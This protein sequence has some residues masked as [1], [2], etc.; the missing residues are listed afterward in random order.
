MRKETLLN[1]TQRLAKVGGWYAEVG[2][3]SQPYWTP[4]TYEIFEYQACTPP[5][6]EQLVE[7]IL[8]QYRDIM[9]ASYH[10]SVEGESSDIE[11]E[12][13]TFKGR[14][15]WIRLISD[16]EM[17]A[18]GKVI[19]V[20]GAVMDITEQKLQEHTHRVL[21]ERLFTTFESMTDA[22]YMMD[23]DWRLI[24]INEA[25]DKL[26]GRDR[27]FGIGRNI[28]EVFPLLM[29][30]PLYEGF[31]A[32]ML[33]NEPF[34]VEYYS[35]LMKNW[36]ELD[37]YPS[38]E[39]LS[40]FFHSI[41]EKRVMAD[42]IA[43]SEQRLKYVTQATLDAAWDWNLEKDAVWWSGRL[44]KLFCWSAAETRQEMTTDS[45]YWLERIHPDERMR[46]INNLENLIKSDNSSWV[47]SYRLLRENGEYAN[48]EHR[49]FIA[50]GEDGQ[51]THVVGGITD[52]SKRVEMEER[53]LQSQRLE[54]IGKLTGHV[55][56][57][58][59]N[60][61]TVILGNA[62]LLQGYLQSSP[63]LEEMAGTIC[64]AAL[65]GSDLT[66]RLLAFARRQTLEPRSLDLNLLVGN[67]RPLLQRTL[68]VDIDIQVYQN[69]NLLPAL[70]DANQLEGAL[71]NLCLNARDAMPEGGKLLIETATAE[72]DGGFSDVHRDLRPGS[73]V[74]LSVTDSGSGIPPELIKHVIEP[75]FT[76]KPVG[77]GTGLGLSSVFGFV[78]QSNGNLSI[79]S[80]LG[81]GTTVRLYLPVSSV[82][83]ER[84]PLR[85][86]SIKGGT[87]TILIVDDDELVRAVAKSLLSH[88]LGYKVH[89]MP[90]ARSALEFLRKGAQ[91]D[92]VFTDVMMPGMN[93]W[94]FAR[95]V[96]ASWP[97][98]KI[99][100][101]SGF[102]E[103]SIMHDGNL[104]DDFYLL[105]KPYPLNELAR[106]IRE[107]LD[108][109]SLLKIERN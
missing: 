38:P 21:S 65:K 86:Q 98:M 3:S 45:Y 16:P 52:I 26:T 30:T 83:A 36:I 9:L 77:K 75:F 40:V 78:K 31:H 102:T 5:H 14:H 42:R 96:K 11:V 62:E 51:A 91:V 104:D 99:L 97:G 84:L 27:S 29:E 53:M 63:R 88:S 61:L 22:F 93:G 1:L 109:N 73:Y 50:R 35:D 49:A 55:A 24:Y 70:A 105:P 8:P 68:G 15:K 41:T 10:R 71:L 46:V 79:Y 44:E 108:E 74:V 101:T 107:V 60:L 20:S 34:H 6:F 57:D 33:S 23:Q 64:K 54:S 7:C 100:F 67:M 92:L 82:Q 90:D 69:A 37:A 59:N 56:H 12:M 81:S 4:E 39:G 76:T 85:L 72:I 43:A 87:E 17:D 2:E 94:E 48:V 47:E 13:H 18:T 25:A 106:K 58:F 80:E 19:S 32:A 95:Q 66:S 103:N 89:V 28:W